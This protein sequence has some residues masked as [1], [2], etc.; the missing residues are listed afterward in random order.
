MYQALLR[1]LVIALSS[2][3]LSAC[4]TAPRATLEDSGPGAG[5]SGKDVV[6]NVLSPQTGR[7]V[8]PA[9]TQRVLTAKPAEGKISSQY[10]LRK[11]GS[12]KKAKHHKGIDVST[13]K[14]ASVIAA[15]EGKVTFVGK[16]GAYGKLVEITHAGGMVTRYAHLNA[17]SVK[18]G[19]S[20]KAGEAIGTVGTTGRTT[21]P[22]LHF[23]VLVENKHV[24]PLHLVE[25]S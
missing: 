7:S 20:V 13:Y 23:E 11:L 18:K 8:K 16:R 5:Y 24:N 2:F 17:F 25:W 6:I 1:I 9:A 15:G 19:Q 22:N 12:R 4:V 21:G 3:T 14:G 10:G